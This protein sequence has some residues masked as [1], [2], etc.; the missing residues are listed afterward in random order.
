MKKLFAGVAFL[1]ITAVNVLILLET[2]RLIATRNYVPY[3][4]NLW[5]LI[6]GVV[7]LFL[8]SITGKIL[9]SDAFEELRNVKDTHSC[10]GFLYEASS[11][12]VLL[13]G[14]EAFIAFL[15]VFG[16]VGGTIIDLIRY[17]T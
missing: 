12:A 11:V 15:F 5:I 17:I 14:F 2:V 8:I 3:L 4:S 9:E 13:V 10:Y 6:A 7:M 1:V 16:S